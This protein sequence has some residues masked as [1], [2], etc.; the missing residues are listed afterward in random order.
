MGF[1]HDNFLANLRVKP[2]RTPSSVLGIRIIP[3]KMDKLINPIIMANSWIIPLYI[4]ILVGGF[5]PSEKY[6]SVGIIIPNIWKVIKK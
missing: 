1:F 4:Y 2:D 6:L 5:N 3:K